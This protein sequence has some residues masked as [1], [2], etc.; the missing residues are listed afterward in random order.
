MSARKSRWFALFVSITMILS[1]L[2]LSAFTKHNTG[3]EGGDAADQTSAKK[4]YSDEV[5]VKELPGFQ[6]GYRKVNGIKI[7]YVEGG[8]G[9]PLFLL[10]GWPQTW[11]AFHKIMPALAEKY[12]VYSIDYRGMGSSG[13]PETG[14]D[15]K[16]MASDIYALAKEL[17]YE[18]VNIAGHD[19]GATVAY[20][21]AANYPQATK[22]LA[23]LDASH[24]NENFLKIPILPPNGVYDESNP[25]RAKFYWWF[26]FNTVP[27][28]PEQLLQGKQLEIAYNW[29][30][31]YLGY[32]K[33]ALSKKE[34]EIYIAAY[35]KP[36]ALRAGH[37]WYRAFR[38][39][40][41]DMKTYPKLSV[42]VL[43]IGGVS[44]YDMLNSFVQEH[45]TDGKAVKLE[46]T[47]HWISEENPQE[48]IH[49]FTEFFK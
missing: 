46:K 35:A 12:H 3:Q 11:Y 49:Q 24:P 34:R 47:G 40:I 20:A 4:A 38:Q 9:E 43:G 14:Y 16:T 30:Y 39:D 22:K 6:N 15:K 25:E 36:G 23:L 29:M 32:D 48:T 2:L 13:K 17:G 45:A 41:E 21:F 26:A 31:D 44:G 19:I 37:N 7:H 10:P 42:P 1:L 27:E 33:T 5:L 28:L 8:K 18:K